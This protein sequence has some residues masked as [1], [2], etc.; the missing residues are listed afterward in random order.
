MPAT[1]DD[2]Q[3]RTLVQARQLADQ[4]ARELET[5]MSR[6]MPH[7]GGSSE[8]PP[9][10]EPEELLP[11]PP[12][13]PPSNIYEQWASGSYPSYPPSGPYSS[14]MA[15]ASTMPYASG[16]WSA[17]LPIAGAPALLRKTDPSRR[18]KAQRR[19][20]K[21]RLHWAVLAMAIAI[22]LGLW[23]DPHARTNAKRQLTSETHRVVK[24][25]SAK[26]ASAKAAATMTAKRVSARVI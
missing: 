17:T 24:V 25:V 19:K 1:Y 11:P 22:A 13:L 21:S 18:K 26:A 12:S 5:T 10:L 8:P 7:V 20:A 16:P 4:I 2:V 23:R 15:Y 3:T 14:P 9:E 6:P